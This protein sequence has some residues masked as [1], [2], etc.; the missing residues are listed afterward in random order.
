MKNFKYN[1]YFGSLSTR[2]K[3]IFPSFPDVIFLHTLGLQLQFK[4]FPNFK[5]EFKFRII[6]N[7]IK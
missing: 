7:H 6:L 3:R 2:Y 1:T 4:I 5:M